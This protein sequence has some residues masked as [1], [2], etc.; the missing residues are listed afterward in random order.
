[1]IF[2]SVKEV[3]VY[4]DCAVVRRGA[5]V[6]LRTGTNEVI[7][8]GL[9]KSADADSL[10]MFFPAGVVSTDVQILPFGEAA[11]SLPSQALSEEIDELESRIRTLKTVEELWIS[12][13]N[14][15][16]REECSAE[17]VE[18]YL[19]ALPANLESLRTQIRAQ[20]DK[21]VELKKKQEALLRKEEVRVVRL[22]LESA[23]DCEVPFEMEYAD[24]SARWLSIYEIHAAADAEEIRVVSRARITQDSGE[25]WENVHLSLYTG[26]PS[27]RQEIPEIRKLSLG[28]RSWDDGGY[29]AQASGTAYAMMLSPVP[30]MKPARAKSAPAPMQQMVMT[31]AGEEEADTMTV[32]SLPGARTVVSGATGTTAELKTETIPVR[33]RVVCVPQIDD[34]A[35]LAAIVKTAEWPMKPSDARIYLN[36]NYCGE[37]FVSPDLTK[38]EFMLSLGRDERVSA[39]REELLSKTEDVLL[40]GQKRK[41]RE[42]A[43]RIG[44]NRENPIDVLVWD[45]IPVSTEK[46]ITVDRVE[47]DGA[48]LNEET[49]KLTWNLTVPGRSAAEKRFGYTVTYPKDKTLYETRDAVKSVKNS[50]NGNKFCLTC[51]AK[52]P[53]ERSFC[54]V[55]GSALP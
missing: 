47:T 38:E 29:Y 17:T 31:N 44:N 5:A 55:C 46:Q 27:A 2:T 51:G 1:M 48:E 9:G 6:S 32:Y 16:A 13:G 52:M 18:N 49:G 50:K 10:R 23:Q 12:N 22:I 19:N 24:S 8:S 45:Q 28:F 3:R 20:S 26:N 41:I 7:V 25:D 33:L 21:C 15:T 36:G 39:K 4:K 30:N 42:Y 34:S 14:F 54:T 53:G 37:T 35:Y 40:K 11:G 43:I